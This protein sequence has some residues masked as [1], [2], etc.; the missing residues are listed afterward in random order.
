METNLLLILALLLLVSMLSILS[1][2]LKISYPI[3]LVIA[4]LLISLIPN[5][6]II[7][8]SPDIVFTLFLPPLLYAAAWNTSWN[9]FWFYRRPIG[10]LAFGLVIFTAGTIA[11][12]SHALIPD[13]SLAMGFLL[14]GIISPPD[15]VAATSVLSGLKVPKRIVTILEGE[16]LIN[17]ASSLIVFRFA[18]FELMT[19]QFML[20][21]ATIDFFKVSLLGIAIGAAIAYIV[22][23]IHRFLPT[24]P[25]I[26]TAISLISPYL[27]YLTAEHFEYSGVLAVVTGGLVLS[28]HS[29]RIFTYSSRLQTYS[30]WNTLVFMLNGVVFILI[31]LQLPHIVKGLGQYALRDAIFYGVIVSL[32]TIVIRII[33]VYPAA[34]VPRFL[35]KRIRTREQRPTPAGVFIIGWS[36]MRGVVSLASALAV[37]TV[38]SNETQFPHRNLIL[39]I[40]FV[41]ILFTLVL[42]GISLPWIIRL[43]RVTSIEDHSKQ[44]QEMRLRMANATLDFLNKEYAEESDTIDAF[45]RV[46]DRYQRMI[47]NINQKLAEEESDKPADDF[48]PKYRKMLLEVVTVRRQELTKMRHER[49]FDE[50]LFRERELELDLEEARLSKFFRK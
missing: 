41:V 1:S 38:L 36:G 8:L 46:K 42:Q 33:W 27:M 17:D 21:N 28:F 7:E 26:D 18:L 9:D 31:G 45:N 48:L 37:P 15:A 29:H 19:G 22:Y 47:D 3:F 23:L 16:S 40:T 34:Y 5:I 44:E 24:T 49:R 11:Y 32:V 13:F 6:P 4:G 35:S 12:V 30:V 50:E 10:L 20:S 2:K 43:L 39:F 14:G 25:S